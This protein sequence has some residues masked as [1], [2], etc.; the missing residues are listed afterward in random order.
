MSVNIQTKDGLKVLADKTTKKTIKNALG[1]TPADENRLPNITNSQ[2]DELIVVDKN[3][4]V[5][6]KID[7]EGLHIIGIK[8]KGKDL[9]KLIEENGFSGDYYDLINRPSIDEGDDTNLYIA[10]KNGNVAVKIDQNG[11]DASN[12]KIKGEQ[13][14]TETNVET[15]LEDYAKQE[16]IPTKM[17]ELELDIEVGQDLP[18]E[19]REDNQLLVIDNGGNIIAKIDKD[20]VHSTEFSE[21]G[22]FLKDK[23]AS[24]DSVPTKVSQ[25]ENDEDYT[26]IENVSEVLVGP[27]IDEC[28]EY[29]DNSVNSLNGDNIKI[30]DGYDISIKEA[31]DSK[32]D[33]TEASNTYLKKEDAFSGD[34]EK[35]TNK[36]ITTDDSDKELHITDNSGN[37]IATIDLNGIHTTEL[38]EGGF[39]LKDKYLQ[40]DEANN[41][42]GTKQSVD[43]VELRLQYIENDY[44]TSYYADNT[45]LT[46]TNAGQIYLTKN[47]AA[48]TYATKEEV[49]SLT[50]E[51]IYTDSNET[52]TI[53]NALDTIGSAVANKLDK[54]TAA[55]TY[56]KK[57][58]LFSGSYDDLTDK[59]IETTDSDEVLYIVDGTGNILAS[60]T[61]EGINAAN[62]Q[63]KSVN[64][65][66]KY[67]T[68]D[69]LNNYPTIN[70][71]AY[72]ITEA[73]NGFGDYADETY[74]AKTELESYLPLTGGTVNGNI[75]ANKYYVNEEDGASVEIGI[76]ANAIDED[77]T[78]FLKK[79][80]SNDLT[81]N[82]SHIYLTKAGTEY[83]IS[84][85]AASGELAIAANTIK[86]LS[87]SGKTI[88]Y[89]KGD[90]ATGT[91]TT[92]DTTYSKI[93]NSG[94]GLARSARFYYQTVAKLNGSTGNWEASPVDTSSVWDIDV[95]ALTTTAGRYYGV[96]A[97]SIGRLFVNVPWTGGGITQAAMEQYIESALS[98]F[99]ADKISS[100]N[101]YQ[102]TISITALATGTKVNVVFTIIAKTSAAFTM[103]SLYGLYG[104]K[105]FQ[106]SG[107][108]N[109]SNVVSKIAITSS[110]QARFVY[111]ASGSTSVE[112]VSTLS[113]SV[114]AVM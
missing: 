107:T 81:I 101:Y 76:G 7:N 59:P 104:N 53:K 111:G 12:L 94:L 96:E 98:D 4:H 56:A 86:D 39:S 58:E 43:D 83:T 62:L 90:G 75:S 64:L 91:L 108:Y 55:D 29:T 106:A 61:N 70:N 48:S 74:A 77:P 113:D 18:I 44:I 99:Y 50:G 17:S 67:A 20:G 66:D 23:Y 114:V 32:L 31:V 35:L 3:G 42:Y 80:S 51:D 33:N 63:E 52:S 112:T 34:Y 89:T 25:L 103:S 69:A 105:A 10:D 19:A 27:A 88:T 8:I 97:D 38:H 28:K 92:Q 85:P 14:A 73:L 84:F 1:Y 109:S 93:N 22:I 45:Y 71:V 13:V 11:L 79:D 47:S 102:H 15:V 21:K 72:R 87:I 78:V 9:L 6:A 49:S 82:H 65:S 41:K 24:K 2:D 68:I 36:P 57:S 26:T 30:G 16:D 37:I 110:T 60:F 54:T 95:N 100:R 5:V 46:I 40:I